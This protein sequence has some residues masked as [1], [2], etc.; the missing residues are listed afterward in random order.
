MTTRKTQTRWAC[1]GTAAP[2]FMRLVNTRTSSSG[3]ATG[4]CHCSTPAGMPV[5]FRS[6]LTAAI[7]GSRDVVTRFPARMPRL[8]RTSL[9]LRA[10]LTSPFAFRSSNESSGRQ[11]GLTCSPPSF[12]PRRQQQESRSD[13]TRGRT[14]V[15]R[16]RAQAV[17]DGPCRHL[18]PRADSQLVADSLDVALVGALGDEQTLRDL[19]VRHSRGDHRRDLSLP[20]AQRAGLG[21]RFAHRSARRPVLAER[22]VQRLGRAHGFPLAP[23]GFGPAPVAQARACLPAFLLQLPC[24]VGPG[25]ERVL[26]GQALG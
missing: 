14:L 25:R 1:S 26:A 2:D 15:K 17:L 23:R 5:L 18:G 21:K 22:V 20:P 4:S 10:P 7:P 8:R 12:S 6:C 11:S 16:R 13:L 3:S 9:T 24:P 19:P